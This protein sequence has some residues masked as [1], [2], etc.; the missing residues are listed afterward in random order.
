MLDGRLS[1]SMSMEVQ[2]EKYWMDEYSNLHD[3]CD[4]DPVPLPNVTSAKRVVIV[5]HGQSTWNA[6][7]R[8][9]GCSDQAVLTQYGKMQAQSTK[10]MVR[11]VHPLVSFLLCHQFCDWIQ[12]MT[13]V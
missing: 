10:E 7:G 9:Q 6:E 4:V 8:I 5:R 2:G 11:P 1:C 13:A 3:R 12:F